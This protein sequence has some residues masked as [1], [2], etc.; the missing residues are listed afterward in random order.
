MANTWD[1]P[2]ED[3]TN[4]IVAPEVPCATHNLCV[5]GIDQRILR[6]V[7]ELTR[8][9]SSRI[10]GISADDFERIES[11]YAELLDFIA[12]TANTIMDFHYLVQFKLTE[13][14]E[15]VPRAENE[16][17][18]S[19]LQYLL[20]ADINLRVSQSTRLNDGL[21]ET[22]QKDLVDAINKSLEII[23]SFNTAFNP[24]D[25]PQSN[26]QTS[27]IMPTDN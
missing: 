7:Q 14:V 20:G 16:A 26:P 27:V 25:Q 3:C 17:L 5:L 24:L 15:N 1:L 11:Y 19:A 21:L 18:N 10:T 6:I 13:L 23:R 2:T 8:N 4:Q 12:K 22:D 9:Q